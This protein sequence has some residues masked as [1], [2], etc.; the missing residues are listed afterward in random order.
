MTVEHVDKL[1][2]AQSCPKGVVAQVSSRPPLGRASL[3]RQRGARSGQ[4]QHWGRADGRKQK[5]HNQPSSKYQGV[6][7]SSSSARRTVAEY[8]LW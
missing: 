7:M 8:L 3:G 1:R 6:K 2:R 5:Q 4:R